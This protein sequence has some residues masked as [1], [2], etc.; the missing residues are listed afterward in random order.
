MSLI[1]T[2]RSPSTSEKIRRI[3]HGS[4]SQ[5][6][7]RKHS[8]P[9][10]ASHALPGL[11]RELSISE[12]GQLAGKTGRYLRVFCERVCPSAKFKTVFVQNDYT[13]S[14]CIEKVITQLSSEGNIFTNQVELFEVIGRLPANSKAINESGTVNDPG[15]VFSE[16]SSRPLPPEER[17]LNIFSLMAPAP[18]LCRRLELRNQLF[19]SSVSFQ[20]R[21]RPRVQTTADSIGVNSQLM[22]PQCPFLL[23]IKG[24]RPESDLLVHSFFDI[25]RGELSEMTMGTSAYNDIRL[26]LSPEAR[27]S[28]EHINTNGDHYNSFKSPIR[29]IAKSHPVS[30][31][32]KAIWLCISSTYN[33][34]Q[35]EYPL[36]V[37]LNWETLTDSNSFPINKSLEPGDILR[38]ET[39]NLVYV[40]IFK[41]SEMVP[42]HNLPLGFLTL[43]QL[44]SVG[45]KPPTGQNGNRSAARTARIDAL[46]RK[47]SSLS[48]RSVGG[49]SFLP[50]PSSVGVVVENLFPRTSPKNGDSNWSEIGG[51]LPD[52]GV[53][54]GCFAHLFRSVVKH[55]LA[56]Y[57]QKYAKH[58][59]EDEVL[60]EIN[61]TLSRELE[62]LNGLASQH[63]I[64]AI[65]EAAFC[66]YVAQYLSPGWLK[67]TVYLPLRLQ[68]L[69]RH[70]TSRVRSADG[71][72]N[73]STTDSPSDVFNSP[74]Q[75]PRQ[76]YPLNAAV[77]DS[78]ENYDPDFENLPMLSALRDRVALEA[79]AVMNHAVQM[80]LKVASRGVTKLCRL[81]GGNSGDETARQIRESQAAL[82]DKL[83]WT[84]DAIT[85]ALAT[86]SQH[87]ELSSGGAPA[88][89]L[90]QA[91]PYNG[92]DTSRGRR[93]TTTAK[94]GMDGGDSSRDSSS[95][96]H[97]SSVIDSD[98]EEEEEATSPSGFSSLHG[99]DEIH[100]T[101]GEEEDT[102][103]GSSATGG[104]TKGAQQRME[105]VFFCRFLIGISKRIIEEFI[106]NRAL[107]INWETGTQVLNLT[108]ALS[109]WM[110]NAGVQNYKEALQLLYDFA[111][112][113]ATPRQELLN[114]G[115]TVQLP[116]LNQKM[117]FWHPFCQQFLD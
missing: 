72:S 48:N 28:R 99:D 83:D 78:G 112:L 25:C 95:R 97:D 41:D 57:G 79:E 6:G 70:R 76:L 88:I 89:R 17:I 54:A 12:V 56:T 37:I 42:E 39:S 27:V 93:P 4:Q 117:S 23:L 29:F 30:V 2:H 36:T 20:S 31:D 116:T 103:F 58:I 87:S 46:V 109:K 77:S 60:R 108:K 62:K 104:S 19:S 90:T 69:E 40:F 3:F 8:S 61:Q 67:S 66:Y 84:G 55:G 86:R 115:V 82:F 107:V 11:G 35:P 85:Q 15:E 21:I 73:S 13:V 63:L 100:S 64:P 110:H 18:G 113:M 22:A 92:G 68:A 32:S 65:W 105:S 59:N 1:D 94:L 74:L 91:Q 24:S 7:H 47:N 71:N 106:E 102:G 52:V 5:I 16:L 51:T 98:E 111:R 80:S 34:T 26:Y 81:F 45:G 9:T 10:I 114:V 43:P 53:A 50:S 101:P 96:R 44:P 33:A 49:S 75:R 14:Q 38:I